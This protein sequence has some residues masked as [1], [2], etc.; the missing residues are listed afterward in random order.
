[1]IKLDNHRQLK[2]NEIIR[3]GD[4]YTLN[5]GEPDRVKFTIG[6]T[7]DD[8]PYNVD[9]NVHYKFYRRKHTKKPAPVTKKKVVAKYPTVNFKYKGQHREVQVIKLDDKYITGLEV[10]REGVKL[11]YQF[12]KFLR[13]RLQSSLAL[14]KLA[15]K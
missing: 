4:L 9:C 8:Y 11:K 13:A 2:P 5:N 10:I 15:D 14:V 7:P 1:M 3:K 12:K 6:R